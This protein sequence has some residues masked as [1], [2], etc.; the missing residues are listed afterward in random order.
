MAEKADGSVVISF[1]ADVSKAD[2]EL[3]KLKKKIA[4]TEA[5]IEKTQKARDEAHQQGIISAEELA[6]EKTKL[7]ELKHELLEI[8]RAAKSEPYKSMDRLST[9]MS[10][11]ENDLIIGQNKKSALVAELEKATAELNELLA[12]KPVL[13]SAGKRDT[14]K[15]LRRTRELQ[16]EIPQIEASIEKQNNFLHET[17]LTLDAVKK[18]YEEVAQKAQEL[19]NAPNGEA[20]N[21]KVEI[22]DQ[23]ERVRL[24]QADYNKIEKSVD[25]YDQKLRAANETLEQHK[26]AAGQLVQEIND[27]NSAFAKMGEA[28][29]AV[30]GYMGKFTSRI[31]KLAKNIFVF[32]L[33]SSAL[34]S[35]KSWLG[36]AIKSND[37]ARASIAKLKGALLTLAQ[38]LVDVIIPAFTKFV[39]ILASLATAI[40]QFVSKI[41]GTT[42]S[43]AAKSAEELYNEQ[44]ALDG[45]GSSAKKASQ[46]LAAF[47]EINTLSTSDDSSGS[48][49][50]T[51]EP[52]FSFA[53]NDSNWLDGAL[54]DVAGKVTTAL[55]LGG[56]AL[57]A[58]GACLGSLRTVLAGLILLGAGVSIGEETGVF[59]SWAEKL[60]LDGVSQYIAAALLLAGIVLVAIGAAT[61]NLTTLLAGLGMLGVGI[62]LAENS[63]AVKS[64]VE[65]LGLDSVNEFIADALILGGIA[66]V[67]IGA[68]MGNLLLLLA[69]LGMIGGGISYAD[70]ETKKKWQETLGLDTVFDYVAAAIQL[71]GIALIAI[72]ACMGNIAMVIAG[73]VVLAIGVAADIIGEETLKGWWEVLKLTNIQQWV[74]VVLLLVGIALI[75]IGAAMGNILMILAGAL[76]L[77]VGVAVGASEGN[78]K[79][80]VTVMG[81]EKVAGWVTAALLL[82]GVALIVFGILTANIM[83]IIAGAGMLGAGIAIG[84]TT[85]TFSS[86]LNTIS[87]AFQSF[88][89]TMVGIFEGLWSG[90]KKII[91]S[92]IDGVESLANKVIT[93]INTVIGAL[94]NLSF[95]IPDWVPALGGKSFGFN[96]KKLSTI[97]IPRL[98]EGAVIPPNREFLAVLGDQ[99]SGTN[100]ETPLSTMVE[101]FKQAMAESGNNGTYTFVVNLD[102]REVA[103]N[104]IRHMNDMTRERGKSVVLV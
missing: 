13:A 26:E 75:A 91:N 23:Q 9:K 28:G 31:E 29:D 88:K 32:T 45:V 56:I 102:G 78:L 6:A 30:N 62:E 97:S 7:Q 80:W 50:S 82:V 33:I 12:G 104:T 15:E 43:D 10:K 65:K 22:A 11:M 84:V 39:N 81:L 27:A 93:G 58:I 103:R 83:M 74:S 100:I 90:I 96:I 3:A 55:L 48:G 60:G 5:E 46:K 52:D 37:E 54:G 47:D 94:N 18:Q 79:D 25:R 71:A 21:L 59:N 69:G 53:S 38:P 76:S 101:A 86:W 24:L 36:K 4:D 61:M 14:E 57:V 64:W 42:A 70:E 41:F 89:N 51:I 77:G 34:Q 44:K 49:S 16:K 66:L 68:A 2:K 35:L 20:T 73:G 17:E 67:A 85:G 99:R 87:G 8:Q 95:T 19:G 92:I 1:D 63:E 72:G 98:A 40:A